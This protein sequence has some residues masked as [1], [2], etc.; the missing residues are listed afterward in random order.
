M[1][2]RL[3]S[4]RD[5]CREVSVFR[6]PRFNH[7]LALSKGMVL[8]RHSRFVCSRVVARIPVTV[9]G[10]TG[11]VVI[12]KTK[13]NNIIHRLA[14][15]SEIERVSL[16]RVSPV[17]IRT[18]HT[19][20]PRGTYELSSEEMRL[21]CRG[22]LH[23]VQ[24]YRTGCSLVV[25]SSSSPFNPSRKLFAHRF[26]KGYCGTLGRSKVV[27][28]RRKDPF[29]TRSTRTVRQ[30]RGEV[31]DAFRVDHICRTRVPAFTTNC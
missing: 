7:I 1:G 15:C 9:R 20:L 18:Y 13:S 21:R 11:R 22:T 31:T 30:D 28:G 19:C 2:H 6:A 3:F 23:F 10:R 14:E 24:E 16:M 4:E 17:I 26:C 29:C 25:M 12:V 5:S 8:A 27:I